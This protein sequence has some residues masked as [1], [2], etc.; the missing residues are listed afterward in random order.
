[1]WPDSFVKWNFTLLDH[2]FFPFFHNPGIAQSSLDDKESELGDITQA[3][4]V[5]LGFPRGCQAGVVLGSVWYFGDV[6]CLWANIFHKKQNSRKEKGSGV[7]VGVGGAC[8][9][10]KQKQA[11]DILQL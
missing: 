6:A 4:H 5:W 9:R 1:M 2:S 8:I 10:T 11:A 3:P 7:G